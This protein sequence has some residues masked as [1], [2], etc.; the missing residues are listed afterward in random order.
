MFMVANITFCLS[1]HAHTH[2]E[3]WLGMYQGQ[4]VAIKMP[5]KPTDIKGS[6]Q[7]LA[8]ASIMT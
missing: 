4:K 5:L 8:E 7:L 3:V 2:T 1:I 6:R